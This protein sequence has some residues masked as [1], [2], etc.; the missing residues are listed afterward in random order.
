MLLIPVKGVR[1]MQ[2]ACLKG[3]NYSTPVEV[4]P[5]YK[6]ETPRSPSVL[7]ILAPIDPDINEILGTTD[8]PKEL[9]GNPIP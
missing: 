7:S 9:E 5:G 1:V 6:T 8:R 4:L 3:D 2:A